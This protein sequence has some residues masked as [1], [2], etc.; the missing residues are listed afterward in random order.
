V[1]R[2][3]FFTN[4][5]AIVVALLMCFWLRLSRNINCT[6]STAR[7]TFGS[8]KWAANRSASTVAVGQFKRFQTEENGRVNRGRWIRRI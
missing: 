2:T 8:V 6:I 7:L 4:G 1:V 5:A 3:A